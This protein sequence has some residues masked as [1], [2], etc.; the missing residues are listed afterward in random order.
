M[1]LGRVVLSL[2]CSDT[3]Q[4]VDSRYVFRNIETGRIQWTHPDPGF[5]IER[6]EVAPRNE[7]V[8]PRYE[9]V[10]Y[11]WGNTNKSEIIRVDGPEGPAKVHVTQSLSTVLRYLR[12]PGQTRTLWIDAL[13]LN[14]RNRAELSQQVPRMRDIYTLS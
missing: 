9:T 13:C 3:C 4:I 6:Y 11:V 2:Q 1:H 7:G 12:Y 14:Q 5:H 10:S 8:V